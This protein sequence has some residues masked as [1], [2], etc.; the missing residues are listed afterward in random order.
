L[1]SRLTFPS[2]AHR[3]LVEQQAHL[4]FHDLL[5]EG[6]EMLVVCA[7]REGAAV[8]VDGIDLGGAVS[9]AVFRLGIDF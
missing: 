9:F 6:F 3:L 7:H 1:S 4:P 8:I 5:D 2:T